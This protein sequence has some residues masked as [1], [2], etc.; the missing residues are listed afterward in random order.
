MT[1]YEY[2]KSSQKQK[3]MNKR[4]RIRKEKLESEPNK[5]VICKKY[6]SDHTYEEV[7]NCF[8]IFLDNSKS[9]K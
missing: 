3:R 9:Q 1:S 6:L 2:E 4:S 5:C 7:K 8:Q